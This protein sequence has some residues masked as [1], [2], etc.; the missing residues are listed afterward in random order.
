MGQRLAIVAQ[1]PAHGGGQV[2]CFCLQP[3]QPL[4]VPGAAQRRISLLGQHPV[5]VGITAPDLTHVGACGQLLG[6]ERADSFQHPRP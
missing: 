5:I 4:A 2:T 3:F 6:D 1:V